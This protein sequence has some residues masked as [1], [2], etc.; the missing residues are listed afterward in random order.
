MPLDFEHFRLQAG[1]PIFVDWKSSPYR[2]GEIIVWY[3]RAALAAEFYGAGT[4]AEAAV[5]LARIQQLQTVTHVVLVRD[6]SAA[7]RP[8]TY[9]ALPPFTGSPRPPDALALCT[10]L[11]GRPVFHDRVYLLCDLRP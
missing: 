5:A 8:V 10:A 1:V 2:S 9:L 4:A 11:A 3:Q 7:A 6:A